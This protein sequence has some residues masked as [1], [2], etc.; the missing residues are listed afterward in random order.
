MFPLENEYSSLLPRNAQG[1]TKR[2]AL[3]GSTIKSKQK[4][5]PV[6]D[7]Y[8]NVKKNLKQRKQGKNIECWIKWHTN[9]RPAWIS[10]VCIRPK[11]K[12]ST[13]SKGRVD[14]IVSSPLPI[15]C[16]FSSQHVMSMT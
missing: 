1:I 9:D 5:P 11:I 2:P 13:Q 8:Y 16:V 7:N 4:P 6:K 14:V 15:S 10:S 12:V 3:Y